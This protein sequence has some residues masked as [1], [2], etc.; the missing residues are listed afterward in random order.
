MA[1]LIREAEMDPEERREVTGLRSFAMIAFILLIIVGGLSLLSGFVMFGVGGTQGVSAGLTGVLT[2]ALV[3]LGAFAVRYLLVLF[4]DIAEDTRISRELL[5]QIAQNLSRPSGT[6]PAAQQRTAPPS[7]TMPQ[8]T[9]P[10]SGGRPPMPS[11]R[12]NGNA[13]HPPMPPSR[14]K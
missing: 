3:V 6:A 7:R 1:Y 10:A 13:A 12:G 8:T 14:S 11:T 4:A 5:Q 9:R 2:G